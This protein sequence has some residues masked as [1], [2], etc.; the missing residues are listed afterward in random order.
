[1]CGIA[2][3]LDGARQTNTEGLYAI[4][5][6][7]TTVLAHRGP[8]SKGAWADA[9]S[10]IAL[11]HR[12]L[13]I[14]DLSPAGHQPMLSADSRYVMVFNG[15]VFNHRALRERLDHEHPGLAFRGHSDTEVMLAAIS[16][17]GLQAAVKQ[18]IGMF[19]FALWDR[20][21]RVLHL[22]RDRLGIKPLY[23]GWVGKVLV[24][25]SE[26]K[27]LRVCDGFAGAVNHDVLAL[28]FRL[29]YVPAPY[30]IYRDIYKLT[31]GCILSV[32]AADPSART[33]AVP[34]WTVDEV[35]QRGLAEPFTGTEQDAV[36]HLDALLRDAVKLRMEADVPLGAFLSGGVDSSTVV[37]MM[38]AQ[39]TRPVRT[40]CIGFQEAAYDESRHAQA[41]ARHLGTDHV[42]LRATP[43]E[44][45]DVIPRLPA[46]Y[47]EPFADASQIPT[48]LVS[49]LARQ[50]VTVSLSGDGG[51]E[52]FYGYTR[53]HTNQAFS[54]ALRWMPGI[55]RRGVAGAVSAIPTRVLDGTLGWM[56]PTL[57]KYGGGGG[58]VGD[59]LHQIADMLAPRTSAEL[60]VRQLSR[61]KNP[62]DLVTGAHEPLTALTDL[63]RQASL[64][65]GVRRMMFADSLTFLPDDILVKVDRASMGVSLEARVPILDHRVFEF[66]WSL[67]LALRA[68]HRQGK[69]I[70]REVLARYVPRELIERPKMGFAV[71]VGAWLR[72]PLK[73]WAE[74]LLDR[75]RLADSGLI[76]PEPVLRTWA[77]HVSGKRDGYHELWAV[78]M[79]QAWQQNASAEQTSVPPS[80]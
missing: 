74:A 69:W 51:D 52:L 20:Q 70:L 66:A 43:Q 26:L 16:C 4:T 71:P 72:G 49:R 10:G 9:G 30:S 17:W 6:R 78:L 8:D 62:T 2:G 37:A 15:E 19:A 22:V 50:S 48:F 32:R 29:G 63:K 77:D 24:F 60:Y 75:K 3:Y 55:V 38:Q 80:P 45:M 59:N 7:M 25:G 79:F 53:Y 31:P 76:N 56:A 27:A 23:Y 34:F 39:S 64:P 65:D 12:R 42:E 67:P 41:V 33:Q 54:R 21:E 18:F 46:L 35:A 57:R 58:S 1:M 40:F 13:S 11:G 68:Q 47:D 28:Y 73:D 5:E 61:W 36:D 44:A 14:I